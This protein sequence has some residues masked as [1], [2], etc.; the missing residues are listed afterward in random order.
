MSAD[1]PLRLVVSPD[2]KQVL[3]ACG[4]YN[5]TGLAVLDL[6]EKRVTRFFPLPCV[7]NGLVFSKDGRRL[8]VSGGDSGVLHVFKYEGGQLAP[9]KPV[10]PAPG[11]RDV[12]LAGLAVDRQSGKLYA[13][14][15][16]GHEVW[17]IHADSLAREAAIGVGM[18][19]HSCL[20]GADRRHL[21]VSNWG[22]RSVSVIDTLSGRKVRDIVVG[23]R[24]NEM[25]LSP[26]AASSSSA[27]ATTRSTSSRHG[28][29]K[30]SRPAPV[31]RVACRRERGR[32]SP[33]RSTR[34][35]PREA[36]PTPWR[37]HPMARRST[38][39]TPTT[40]T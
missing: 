18:H 25:A 35:R 10:K 6:A 40:T 4:G 13:C 28:P 9:D 23:V 34:L 36:R 26:T 21:Y 30:R 8:Y 11:V 24:P 12:F 3:A 16:S 27:P 38:W 7:F 2:G 32:S 17:V 37:F 22:S 14:N 5:N 15:E 39:P 1:L 29:W 33:R 31:R 19:P 20:F